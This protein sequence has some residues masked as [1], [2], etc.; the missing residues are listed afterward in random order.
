MVKIMA[1]LN[2]QASP[3]K[4]ARR[5]YIILAATILSLSLLGG[6]VVFVLSNVDQTNYG[7]GPVKIA[8][9][10]D[11][12]FYLQGEMVGFAINVRN[13]GDQPVRYPN[14]V[15]YAIEKEGLQVYSL[16]EYG[17]YAAGLT[18]AFPPHSESSLTWQWN[19]ETQLN[20]TSAQ[21][22]LG[23]YTVSISF[24]P[25]EDYGIGGNCTFEIR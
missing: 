3:K 20:E 8:V 25:V 24:R 5:F 14:S 4:K 15:V 23:N 17:D 18:P 21:V 22:Q 1:V 19:P 9:A 2:S 12:P 6:V 7:S 11:K 16:D 13:E 10:T